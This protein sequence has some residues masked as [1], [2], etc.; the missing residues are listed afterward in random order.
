MRCLFIKLSISYRYQF[1]IHLYFWQH[2][3]CQHIKYFVLPI[4]VQRMTR[5]TLAPTGSDFKDPLTCGL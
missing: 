2:K 3:I 5:Q 4:E 1:K